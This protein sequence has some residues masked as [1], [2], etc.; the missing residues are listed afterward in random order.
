[1]TA[2]P[3]RLS[4][5]GDADLRPPPCRGAGRLARRPEAAGVH[6]VRHLRRRDLHPRLGHRAGAAA[7]L[8][9]SA[10]AATQPARAILAFDHGRLPSGHRTGSGPTAV[11]PPTPP[12]TCWSPTGAPD[13]SSPRRAASS[14]PAAPGP[15]WA[16]G[17]HGCSASHE[18]TT[19]ARGA[20][21]RPFAAC[22]SATCTRSRC[23]RVR[24]NARGSCSPFE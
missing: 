22:S 9:T 15:G 6:L 24:R 23:R 1:M 2:N 8:A 14:P 13:R 18:L 3:E 19:W 21:L 4:A 20:T 12:P 7:A 16:C 11:S 5:F 10:C 17:C